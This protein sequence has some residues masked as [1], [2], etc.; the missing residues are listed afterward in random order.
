MAESKPPRSAARRR[1]LLV[2]ASVGVAAILLARGGSWVLDRAGR[3]LNF[4]EVD[5]PPGFRRLSLIGTTSS[6]FDPFVG[7]ET[8]DENPVNNLTVSDEAFCE[9]LF[10]QNNFQPGVVPVAFFSDYNCPNCELIT[11]D[12]LEMEAGGRLHLRYHEWPILGSSSG[13]F[14]RAAIAARRQGAQREFNRRLQRTSFA[15]SDAYLRGLAESAGIDPERL[16]VDMGSEATTQELRTSATLVRRF[17]FP[18]TPALVV[19]RTIVI[20]TI[21]TATLKSLI[22]AE[23]IEGPPPGC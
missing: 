12:L 16:L 9:A 23:R 22:A 18:G 6:A 13:V 3:D 8:T 10:G 5:D 17:A 11:E 19:G 15:P 1:D 4:I 7:M 20:G 14:A 2:F 21:R